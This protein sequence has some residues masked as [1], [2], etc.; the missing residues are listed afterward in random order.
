M[1]EA[2]IVKFLSTDS[3]IKR[4]IQLCTRATLILIRG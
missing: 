4:C 3:A 2:V 1:A